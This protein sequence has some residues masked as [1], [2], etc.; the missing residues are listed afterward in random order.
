MRFAHV[1]KDRFL[2]AVAHGRSNYDW[3]G[4]AAEVRDEAGL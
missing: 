1:L 3:I 4:I 2:A